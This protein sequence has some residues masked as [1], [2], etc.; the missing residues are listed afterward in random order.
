MKALQTDLKR[1]FGSIGFWVGVVGIVIAGLAGG[2]DVAAHAAGTLNPNMG[3][4]ALQI[5]QSAFVSDLFVMTVPILCTLAYA[6]VFMEEA[7]SRYICLY[8]PRAGRYAYLFSKVSATALSGGAAV[9]LGAHIL[10]LI[11]AFAFINSPGSGGEYAMTY[12]TLLMHMAL[13]FIN[14][15]LWALIGGISAV[16]TRNRY[17]AYSCPFIFY[18]VFTSFQKRYYGDFLLLSPHEWIYPKNIA[19]TTVYPAVLVVFAAAFAGY[20]LLMRR[21]LRDG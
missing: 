3:P 12:G 9:F 4:A 19:W 13:L 6:A 8:L 7:K 10:L 15:C 16:A 14:G 21:R 5:A 20:I 1:A 17:M 2:F 18:Y 11:Y